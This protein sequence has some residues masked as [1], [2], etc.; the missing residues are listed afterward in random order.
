MSTLLTVTWSF[1]LSLSLFILLIYSSVF[2]SFLYLLGINNFQTF[3]LH[4]FKVGLS[5]SIKVNFVCFS[6]NPLKIIKNAFY[7]VLLYRK[8]AWQERYG[9][10]QNFWLQRLDNNMRNIF[11]EK[12]CAK[13]SGE[14]S[15]K[16]FHRKI[17]LSIS[18]VWNG[19]KFVFIVCPS[20]SLLKYVKIKVLTT[21]F[22]LKTF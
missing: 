9:S 5:A 4:V 16:S 10:F 22:Y 1:Y 13:C 19:I 20:R 2:M 6:E 18:T 3:F 14:A 21:C 12:S 15:P 17:K 8:T 7:F 11:L